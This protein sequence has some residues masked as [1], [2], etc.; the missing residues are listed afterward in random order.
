MQISYFYRNFI[1]GGQQWCSSEP[2]QQCGR[3]IVCQTSGYDGHDA[4]K[5]GES[6]NAIGRFTEKAGCRRESGDLSADTKWN[7]QRR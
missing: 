3:S 6:P 5:Q 2:I 4:Q 7:H 1:P